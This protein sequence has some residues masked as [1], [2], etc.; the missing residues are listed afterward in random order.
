MCFS[1]YTFAFLSDPF[2]VLWPPVSGQGVATHCVKAVVYRSVNTS[3]ISARTVIAGLFSLH[4]G[5]R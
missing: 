3:V 1:A 2:N 4:T 5:R